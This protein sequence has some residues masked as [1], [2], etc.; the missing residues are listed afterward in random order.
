M[1]RA[2][3]VYFVVGLRPAARADTGLARASGN[4]RSRD[5]PPGST[6]LG[7][8]YRSVRPSPPHTPAVRGHNRVN[9][10]PPPCRREPAPGSRPQGHC[11]LATPHP[12]QLRPS[13]KPESAPKLHIIQSP[14]VHSISTSGTALPLRRALD[15]CAVDA[16]ALAGGKTPEGALHQKSGSDA[17]GG[18]S[19]LN[20]PPPLAVACNFGAKPPTPRRARP[21]ATT[22]SPARSTRRRT[23]GRWRPRAGPF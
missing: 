20:K 3:G 4:P 12:T 15:Q 1:H 6:A 10:L 14:S 21:T 8:A 5:T 22:S 18:S 9:L 16:G 19:I 23:T 17:R 7:T 13:P 2:N 11:P